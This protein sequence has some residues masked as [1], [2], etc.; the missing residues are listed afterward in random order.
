MQCFGAEA[1]LFNDVVELHFKSEKEI[2]DRGRINMVRAVGV[3]IVKQGSMYCT[4]ELLLRHTIQYLGLRGRAVPSGG[5]S[6]RA[7]A[8]HAGTR[9]GTAAT[10]RS[11][12]C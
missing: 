8:R 12:T 11:R 6:E 7:A 9:V 5:G 10:R 4:M 1:E 3:A 2:S